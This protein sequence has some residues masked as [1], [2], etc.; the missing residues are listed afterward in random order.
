MSLK[1][2]PLCPFDNKLALVLLTAWRHIEYGLNESSVMTV[3]RWT[4]LL[5]CS[6]KRDPD[7]YLSWPYRLTLCGLVTSYGDID[8]DERWTR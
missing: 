8:L 2:A 1:F 4:Q 3:T 5:D 7:P 6:E